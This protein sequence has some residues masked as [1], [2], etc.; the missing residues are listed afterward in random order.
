M[1]MADKRTICR[2]M[3]IGLSLLC[4]FNFVLVEGLLPPTQIWYLCLV[5]GF[6]SCE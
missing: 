6:M 3:M 5:Y 2:F 4:F 1:G